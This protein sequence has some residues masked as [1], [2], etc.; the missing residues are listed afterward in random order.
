[1]ALDQLIQISPPS[2]DGVD[3]IP[4]GGETKIDQIPD[5]PTRRAFARNVEVLL[6]FF[7]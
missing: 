3:Q 7:K 5:F 2:G 1:M 6:V 4:E